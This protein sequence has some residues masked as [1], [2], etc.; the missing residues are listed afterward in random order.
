MKLFIYKTIIAVF[1]LYILFEF[2]LGI[3]IDQLKDDLMV[4]ENQQK[5]EEVK[6]KILGEMEKG[7]KKDNFFSE[8]ERVIISNFLNKIINELELKINK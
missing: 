8:E 1:F 7:Y 4:L 2:T 5:R 6:N 3:R